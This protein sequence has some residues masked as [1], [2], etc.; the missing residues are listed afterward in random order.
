LLPPETDI[1]GVER[2]LESLGGSARE[3]S[4]SGHSAAR[5]VIAVEGGAVRVFLADDHR[6]I[7][8]SLRVL[9]ESTPSLEIVGEA[10]DLHGLMSAARPAAPDVIVI[11]LQFGDTLG[12]EAIIALRNTVPTVRIVV[13]SMFEGSP[14]K[15]RALAAGAN[16]YLS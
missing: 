6:V 9:L 11:D 16:A 7:R 1:L 4:S 10:G 14:W 2:G 12:Y 5:A 8:E 15:E 13:L 3:P